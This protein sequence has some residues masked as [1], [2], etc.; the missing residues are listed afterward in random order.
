MSG[1]T[2]FRSSLKKARNKRKHRLQKIVL[3]S[4]AGVL[5]IITSVFLIRSMV[6]K[7]DGTNVGNTLSEE[8][9]VNTEEAEEQDEAT[10][11]EASAAEAEKEKIIDEVIGSYKKLGLVKVDGYL[12]MHKS[13]GAN[14]DIIGKLYGGSA[15]EI[16]DTTKSGWLHIISGGIEGYVH[17][18]YV[19]TG[20]LAKKDAREEVLPR[21]FVNTDK[22]YIR[23][24]AGT[25]SDVVGTALKGERYLV[26]GEE[27]GWVKIRDGYMKKDYVTVRYAINEARKLDLRAMVLNMYDNLG[28]S[29]VDT[30]LNIREEPKEDGKII[31]KM[32]SKAGCNILEK[33]GDWYKIQSGGITGY[34]KGEFIA[35]G[36]AAKDD[37][38]K[39]ASLMAIVNTDVLNAR[40]EPKDSASIWTQLSNKQRYPVVEQ[41]DGWVKLELE[42]DNDVYVKSEYVDVRYALNEAIHFSPAEEAAAAALTRRQQIVN[43]A[44][45]F[46]GNPYV[47]GGTSLTNGC[48]CSGFTMRIME[49]F[50]VGLPH[51][52]GDQARLGSA[53]NSQTIRP[54]D[55]VFYSNSGGTINHVGIYIGNGQIVA[56]AS[57]RSGIK[58]ST[59]DYR[60]PRAIRNVLGD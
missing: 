38:V 34:V 27:N 10:V 29:K 45:Q 41:L 53:V 4:A 18:D 8:H 57:R 50:G 46:L 9:A 40:S 17:P 28:V 16:L 36:Q 12:N 11:S 43:Y 5:I 26:F 37:A 14:S 20:D 23:K 33:S 19:L 42:E 15:C 30:Y 13:D 1:K 52:S 60:S 39:Y 7:R 35:T 2:D 54:G 24:A 51:Y 48:D 59:W 25:D 6:L 47:W 56:A 21:A 44:L 31:G 49:K 3:F 22:L 32:T 55:L 58:I